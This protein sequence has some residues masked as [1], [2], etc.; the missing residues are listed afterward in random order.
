MRSVKS[1]P[2]LVDFGLVPVV[3]LHEFLV[4]QKQAPLPQLDS[5]AVL[6]LAARG[7]WAFDSDEF[8]G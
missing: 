6:A 4:D 3:V 1:D 5:L 2:P 8:S 7:P